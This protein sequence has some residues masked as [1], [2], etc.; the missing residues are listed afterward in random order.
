M[1]GNVRQG[2]FFLQLGNN[3][4]RNQLLCYCSLAINSRWQSLKNE[5]EE[6]EMRREEKGETERR[7][8]KKKKQRR[9]SNIT[10]AGS[11]SRR[12][13]VLHADED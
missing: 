5:E 9:E 10:T 2:R 11:L 12:V 3:L 8:Q 13:I 7:K 1:L 6:K 4:G